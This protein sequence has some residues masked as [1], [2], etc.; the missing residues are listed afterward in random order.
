MIVIGELDFGAIAENRESGTVLPLRDS[1][2]TAEIEIA[3]DV[4]RL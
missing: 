3:K 1:A 4:I 2:R